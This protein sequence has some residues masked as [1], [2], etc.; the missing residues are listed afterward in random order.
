MSYLS[1][2]HHRAKFKNPFTISA[3]IRLWRS[4]TAQDRLRI[5]LDGDPR[6]VIGGFA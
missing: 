6:P 2:Q 3:G 1:N 4:S 5:V